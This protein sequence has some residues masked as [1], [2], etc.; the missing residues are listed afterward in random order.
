MY[1][2][3]NAFFHPSAPGTRRSLWIELIGFDHAA[4]DYNVRNF[5]DG[6]GFVPDMVSLLLTSIGFVLEH[7]DGSDYVLP[8]HVSSYGAHEYNDERRLQSWTRLQLKGLITELQKY[9]IKVYLSFFD[10]LFG[11]RDYPRVVDKNGIRYDMAHLL[12]RMDNGEPLGD[13]FIRKLIGT[14]NDY[15]FDGV[16]IADGISSPRLS[17]Q[18]ADYTIR[19]GSEENTYRE[20]VKYNTSLWSGYIKKLVSAL[21][22]NRTEV[23]FNSAWTRDPLE[24]IYRYGTDYKAF[25]EAGADVLIAENVSTDFA[26]L[27][28][29]DHGYPVGEA[30]RKLVHHEFCAIHMLN[31]A[32]LPS[33]TVTPLCPVR[34]THEQWDVLHHMPTLM[35]RD[36]AANM[37]HYYVRPDGSLSPVVNGPHFCLSD[38]LQKHDWDH[39]R[40]LWDNAYTKDAVDVTGATLVWSDRHLHNELDAFFRC[41]MWHTAKWLTELLRHGAAVHKIV[42]LENLSAVKGPLLLINPAFFD[43]EEVQRIRLYQNGPILTVGTENKEALSPIPHQN[44]PLDGLWTHPLTFA[45]TEEGVAQT[46]AEA[47]NRVSG[48]AVVTDGE[49]ACHVHEI[50]LKDGRRRFLID[51]EQYYYSIPTVHTAGKICSVRFV[52]K[53]KGYAGKVDDR[54]FS[55]RVPPRGMDIVEVTFES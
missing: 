40:L 52:T 54:S 37:N 11:E 41:K 28:N 43:P 2:N 16:Q 5:L 31:K 32:Y 30:Y 27:A 23:A 36:A 8:A 24:A 9:R 45:P 53:P 17:L 14:V 3:H 1:G 29:K 49:G 6:A 50:L 10:F 20:W 25:E 19:P 44:D 46:A 22:S 34:D 15:G 39:L 42:R 18:L 7:E 38:G 51:N 35:L 55:V 48:C 26:I 12:K 33:L 13:Y 21:K 47:I 4:P